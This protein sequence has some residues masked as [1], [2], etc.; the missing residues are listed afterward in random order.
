MSAGTPE[1]VLKSIVDGI[2]AGNLDAL[3]PLYEP[4]PLLRLSRGASLTA[5]K[6]SVKRWP[7][8]LR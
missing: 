4:E 8:S 7:V 5:Y 6:V 2:N 3:M 1:Q